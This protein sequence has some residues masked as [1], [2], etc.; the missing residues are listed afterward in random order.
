LLSERDRINQRLQQIIDERTTGWRIKVSAVDVR[1]A[2]LPQSMQRAMARQAE[3]ER[4]KRA[5]VIHAQGELE[6]SQQLAA[7][8]EVIG[9]QPAALQLRYLQTLTEIAVE[10]NSTIIFPLPMDLLA[11]LLHLPQSVNGHV[12]IEAPSP[13]RVAA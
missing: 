1:D 8:A 10:K 2:E 11:G 13:A 12:K 6:A 7:A 9:S 5:K 3:A 4:E